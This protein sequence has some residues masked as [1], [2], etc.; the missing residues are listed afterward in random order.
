MADRLGVVFVE[1][2][3]D[4]TKFEKG[5]QQII[6]QANSTALSIEKN[7]QI[8]GVKS[9]NIFNAMARG[10]RNAYERI[11]AS[12]KTSAD[13][14]Y[15][16]QAAMVAKI[17]SL[18]QEMTKNPLYETLGI[19]SVAAINAQKDA[20]IRSFDTISQHVQK[21]SQDW[22]N[23]ER[24]KNE[25]LK[26]LG[27]EMVG[28]HEMSMAS[29]TRAILRL[30]AAY[31]VLSQAA[32][33][34]IVPFK[35]GF[36]AVESYNQ[37]VASLAAMVVTFS[38]LKPGQTLAEQW[39]S[40][41][42]YS[43]A[44]V[45]VL[46]QIAA[47]TLLSGQ[48]TTAL[49][50][51]FARSGVF[52]RANNTAQIE[53]FTR[54]SNALPLM[55]KGQEIMR[56]INTEIRSVMTGQNEQ[57]SM[58]LQTLKALPG[59]SKENL[60]LWRQQGTVLENVGRL[61]EGFGPATALLEN[62]WQAVKSTLDTTVTQILRGG[63]LG[64]YGELILS[65]K[66]L[67]EYLK[68]NKD[69]L[70]D[71]MSKWIGNFLLSMYTIKAE[72]L[73]LAMLLDKLGGTLSQIAMG[74]T[75]IGNLSGIS[76]KKSPWLAL[77][78]GSKEESARY[79]EANIQYKKNY[80]ESGKELE[81]LAERYIKL[82]ASIS[83]AGLAAAKLARGG[84]GGNEEFKAKSHIDTEKEAEI[85]RNKF[86]EA[87]A[88]NKQYYDDLISKSDHWL[89]MQKLNGEKDLEMT[90]EV[91]ESKKVTLNSW[92]DRQAIAIVAAFKGDSKLA[93]EKMK[94]WREYSASWNKLENDDSEIAAQITKKATDD[95]IKEIEK[96]IALGMKL[97]ATSIAEI[98]KKE[99]A[100]N[101]ASEDFRKMISENEEFAA[102][103]NERAINKIIGQEEEKQRKLFDLYMSGNGTYEQWQKAAQNIHAATMD[104]IFKKEKDALE[105]QANLY[106]GLIGFEDKYYKNKLSWIE[107]VRI[108]N[109]KLYG[110]EFAD[111]RAKQDI[112][113]LDQ[114]M[115]EDKSAQ[116]SQALG[117]MSST[118]QA[119]S[120]MYDKSSSEY[121]RMQEAAK[122]MIVLQQAVA[123]ANAVAAIANQ[124]LGDPY[125]AFARIAAMAAAMGSLLGSIGVAFSGGSVASAPSAA[126]GLNTTVLG[127]ANDQAS[128]SIEKGWKLLED[129]YDMEYEKLSGIYN[130]MKDL[131]QNITGLA[132]AVIRRINIGGT[133]G[134]ELGLQQ[135]AYAKLLKGPLS[136]IT[137]VGLGLQAAIGYG[138]LGAMAISPAGWIFLGAYAVDKLFGT[139][140]I[141]RASRWLTGSTETSVTGGGLSITDQG[142]AVRGYTDI[143]TEKKGMFGGLFGGNSSSASTAY[144]EID[145]TLVNLISGPQGVYTGIKKSLEWFAEHLGKDTSAAINYAFEDVK[146]DLR[147]L[148]GDEIQK[149]L[150]EEFSRIADV[151]TEAPF[152]NMI[153]KYQE[154]NEGLFETATRL[155]I[156]KEIILSV[157]EMT[158]Q[159]FS[160]TAMKAVELSQ[161]LIGIAGGLDKLTEAASTYYDKFFS[162]EEK[163]IRLQGILTDTFAEMNRALP[164]TREGYRDIVEGLDLTTESGREAYVVLM[165]ASEAA[166]QYYSGIEDLAE[167][168]GKPVQSALD[169]Y[170]R[171]VSSAADK[172][173]QLAE[174]YR[175]I[176]ETLR[177]AMY[178]IVGTKGEIKQHFETT[179]AKAMTGDTE[180]LSALPSL[181]NEYLAAAMKSS[182]TLQEYNLE[183]AYILTALSEA[184]KVTVVATNWAEYQAGVLDSMI[185]ILDNI[186]AEL[187]KGIG[188]DMS[189]IAEYMASLTMEGAGL[190]WE[191]FIASPVWSDY[192][193]GMDWNT[194]I[195][196][197]AWDKY[198]PPVSW[199][200]FVP[201]MTWGDYIGTMDWTG[202]TAGIGG[203]TTNLN[204]LIQ[205]DSPL[206]TL[207]TSF[208]DLQTAMNTF[209]GWMTAQTTILPYVPPPVIQPPP[210]VIQPPPPVT[211][212]PPP[213]ATFDYAAWFANYGPTG[214]LGTGGNALGNAF[215]GG[216]VIPFAYGG[217]YNSPTL[218]PMA[219]GMGL[220]GEAGPEAIM[221]LTR[222]NG[223]LGVQSSNVVSME[224]L[225]EL[226]ALRDEMKANLYAIAKNTGKQAKVTDRWDQDGTPPVRAAV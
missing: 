66:D 119:I 62:Q 54:I 139:D 172:A 106:E 68:K 28:S 156:S 43:T 64:A 161:A 87:T 1:L 190:D 46:E 154:I 6:Q 159:T 17:N 187:D 15:R 157:L 152:G 50:N 185:V 217:I 115:F 208:A 25:K 8:L 29:M 223:K 73:R 110:K 91:I 175:D 109:E 14:Q 97:T 108:E 103:E 77:I 5:Q 191:R 27:K 215:N 218:F 94:L 122:A 59:F 76:E 72:V 226:K 34:L 203:L 90:A 173:R 195:S 181:A 18:N 224:V 11:A 37:S 33:L 182:R 21:G 52:L 166:D 163:Q 211:E 19:R 114:K 55:T 3:L 2:D 193:P 39:K 32:S 35:K 125:T 16:A 167:L 145:Q 196:T 70:I 100:Y 141:G 133:G 194:Y 41:L 210:P 117:Q 30:Y 212:I 31:Y 51:A 201:S 63:M 155:V 178:K 131:N 61:L 93:A 160:G 79:A 85:R 138:A 53:G 206:V 78:L 112:G 197:I 99:K 7:Y 71:E 128:E 150:S 142:K 132:T 20:V 183:K 149:K 184:E 158:G 148:T 102:T 135:P 140:I 136:D 86:A 69:T 209:I 38:E 171:M 107:K 82:E 10:A 147:G 170:Y 205:P 198:L 213:P 84:E 186:Y 4:K 60:E 179:Y 22:I 134:L 189:K 98:E 207:K 44:I 80:E 40:A 57:S 12:S 192:V 116:V 126:Y 56:Q 58:M 118:F 13:E 42:A 105:K 221:P 47:R 88:D 137:T 220:M 67:D 113:K 146:I 165:K 9:D 143:Y 202:A 89:R 129:T 214:L 180:S 101:K 177:D 36:E 45:P 96:Q 24:A 65:A 123:V 81:K 169:S 144:G 164:G 188:T 199:G 121:A 75:T 151:A 104:A 26:E 153:A 204:L 49:A 120:G 216:N 23:I 222:I 127:G 168:M 225:R 74:A 176:G 174:T 95:A 200:S 83:K 48:E 130:E 219:N 111:A 124:G 162:D 92:Y